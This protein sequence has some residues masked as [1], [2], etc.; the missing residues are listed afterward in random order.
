MVF[1]LI[2]LFE[3]REVRAHQDKDNILF[4]LTAQYFDPFPELPSRSQELSPEPKIP[5][6]RPYDEAAERARSFVYRCG[7]RSLYRYDI[8]TGF[9]EDDQPREMHGSLES[10]LTNIEIISLVT[11]LKASEVVQMVKAGEGLSSREIV[12]GVLGALSGYNLGKWTGS[13][14]EPPCDSPKL[15]EKLQDEKFQ[16]GIGRALIK[17]ELG[18]FYLVQR[19]SLAS[20]GDS[21]PLTSRAS[22]E[23]IERG[24]GVFQSDPLE[25]LS[26]SLVYISPR[27]PSRETV[28]YICAQLRD[29]AQRVQ[30]RDY[31]AN[32]NDFDIA[33]YSYMIRYWLALNPGFRN[34]AFPNL[35]RIVDYRD[36]ETSSFRILESYLSAA[37]NGFIQAA[38]FIMFFFGSLAVL[39][40]LVDGTLSAKKWVVHL[41]KK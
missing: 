21:A 4:E 25:Q 3:A 5:S 8:D 15:F 40:V 9:F 26:G 34:S 10:S 28:R 30:S 7:G 31:H 6:L 17:R 11:G 20:G 37:D 41:L 24:A 29:L 23:S 36:L 14:R 27:P 2:G 16:K 1:F 12:A 33:T 18:R 39:I 19:G 38:Y 32:T 22:L 13:F 35:Y